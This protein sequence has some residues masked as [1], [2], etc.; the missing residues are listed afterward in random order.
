MDL[1]EGSA[2]P[3]GDPALDVAL[4]HALLR[5]V[6]EGRRGPVLRSYR[7]H[8]TVAFGRRDTFLPGFERAVAAAR[9]RNFTSVVRG[10]GGRAAA[11]DSGCL[12]FDEIMPAEDSTEG[13]QARFAIE[14][15]LQARALRRLG[16]DA[17]VGHVP[18]EYCPGE[19]SVNAR[20]RTKLI[21]AAQRIVHG[22]WLLSTVVVI[23]SGPRIKAVLEDVYA[24]L[25]LEW[26]PATAGAV[27]DEIPGMSVENVRE[28]ILAQYAERAALTPRPLAADELAAAKEL[29][30]RYRV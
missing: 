6:A 12:V 29:A 22:G 13:I 18:G 19:F 26:D 4:P 23:E 27:A 20:G 9:K 10:A 3:G 21:G 14:A 25:G 15:E 8:P 24:E 2:D 1:L 7:P 11:Y 30:E 16:V 28:A 5:L 17:R